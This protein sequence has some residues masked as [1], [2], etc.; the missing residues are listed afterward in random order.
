MSSAAADLAVRVAAE[1]GAQDGLAAALALHVRDA[2]AYETSV[3]CQDGGALRAGRMMI[4]Q[5]DPALLAPIARALG[6]VVPEV[7][8]R[9][10]ELARAERVP[11]IV[12]WDLRGGGP[13]RCLKLYV[14][15][16]DASGD[17]RARLAAAL[18]PGAPPDEP[19]AVIGLNARADGG[20]ETKLYLQSADALELARGLGA[21]ASALAA[22]ARGE[23]A[24]AGGVASFDLDGAA[25]RARAFF[26]ALREPQAGAWR[27]VRALPGYD[28][29]AIVSVL[30]F[31][32]APPRSMGVSLSDGSWTLYCKPRGSSRAPEALEPAAVFRYEGVEL[33]VYVEPSEHAARA[34]R[35]TERHAV[36]V[37]VRRGEPAARALDALVDWF[38]ERLRAAERDG[39][40]EVDESPPPPWTRVRSEGA[41]S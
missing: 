13:Q 15:A 21:R 2:S 9:W 37:R 27:C 19:A 34:I 3:R 10:L 12:G 5:A 14:N 38:T 33:G 36:S 11:L 31:A 22:A 4:E 6:V 7:A 28:E 18:A 40:R 29:R 1:L 32:P 41:R 25:L 30:P 23:G 16:S 24:D 20:V 8:S 17:A 26:V 39:A 35:R